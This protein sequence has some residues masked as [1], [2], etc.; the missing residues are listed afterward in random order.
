MTVASALCYCGSGLLF[1]QCCDKFLQGYKSA[2]TAEQLMRSRYSAYAVQDRRYLNATWHHSTRPANL[3]LDAKVQWIGL[4]IKTVIGGQESD[5]TGRVEFVARYKVNGR[6]SRLHE[7]S[8]FIRQG[9]E[10]FY[11]DGIQE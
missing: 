5:Q 11:V 8:R 4:D 10:W 7:T 3:Q 9:L 1:T 6:A 2:P